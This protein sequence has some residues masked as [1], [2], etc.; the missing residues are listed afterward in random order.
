MFQP[1][2]FLSRPVGRFFWIL[3]ILLVISIM[4]GIINPQRAL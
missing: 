1:P 2:T 4:I 3:V